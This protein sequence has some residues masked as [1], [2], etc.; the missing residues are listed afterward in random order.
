MWFLAGTHGK[1]VVRDCI[2]PSSK[3]ILF[4]VFN[5]ECSFA[6][7]LKSVGQLRERAR[8]IQD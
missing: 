7:N 5:T 2:I 6:E 3:A 4:P 1:S 8:D